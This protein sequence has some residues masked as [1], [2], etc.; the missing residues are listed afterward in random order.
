MKTP[1]D[2]DSANLPIDQE[3][4]FDNLFDLDE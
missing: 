4:D 2:R 1:M 3:I